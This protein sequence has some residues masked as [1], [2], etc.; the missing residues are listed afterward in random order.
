MKNE[1]IFRKYVFE[2]MKMWITLLAAVMIMAAYFLILY[3]GVGFVQDKRFFSSAPKENLAAIPDTKERFR[4]AHIIGWLIIAAALLTFL[5]AAALA[6]GDGIKNDFGFLQFF[7]RFLVMLY[8]MEVYDIFFFDW[9]LLCHSNFFPYFYPELKG[10]VGP[11]MFGYNKKSHIIHFIVYIPV[12][13]LHGYAR[14]FENQTLRG[15]KT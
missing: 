10:I 8:L 7:V 14:F 6:I 12:P 1:D 2:V 15:E 3:G 9:V 5:G 4:G 13:W 11:H